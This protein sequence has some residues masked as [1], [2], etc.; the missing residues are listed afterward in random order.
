MALAPA[1]RTFRALHGMTA[2]PAICNEGVRLALVGELDERALAAALA[3]L[4]THHEALRT[5]FPSEDPNEALVFAA[6]R[7]GPPPLEIVD[8]SD[9]DASERDAARESAVER[10]QRHVFDLEVPPLLRARLIREDPTHHTLV[11]V[12]HH[13]VG[14]GTSVFQQLPRELFERYALRVE[15]GDAVDGPPASSSGYECFQRWQSEQSS[16]PLRDA[17]IAFW[18]SH[19]EGAPTV[20]ELPTRDPRPAV[21]S[22]RGFRVSKLADPRTV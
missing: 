9:R 4:V 18:R 20:L 16:P 7:V 17:H 8:L 14:D 5:G 12:C 10:V 21:R 13:L 3:D 6:N 19:L 1:Q 2:D 15:N 22:F 11:I